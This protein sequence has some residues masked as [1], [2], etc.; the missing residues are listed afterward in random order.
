MSRKYRLPKRVVG[1]KIESSQNQATR[2][3]YDIFIG[4]GELRPDFWHVPKP[5]KK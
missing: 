5:K 2:Y 4:S 3:G 1:A